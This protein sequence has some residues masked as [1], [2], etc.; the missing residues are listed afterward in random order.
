MRIHLGHDLL[1]VR[2]EGCLPHERCYS[3]GRLKIFIDID[4][5]GPRKDDIDIGK[6]ETNHA[7]VETVDTHIMPLGHTEFPRI[8]PLD[9]QVVVCIDTDDHL[10]IWG[11]DKGEFRMTERHYVRIHSL[12]PG[13]IR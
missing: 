10:M 11:F 13:V 2:P 5:P 6:G 1:E 9:H 3:L 4:D 12:D 8:K 7:R